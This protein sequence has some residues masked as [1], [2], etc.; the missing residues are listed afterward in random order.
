MDAITYFVH[1]LAMTKAT[2]ILAIS[3]IMTILIGGASISP[4]MAT[5][6]S[7][8]V[9]I[10][11]G[12][13]GILDGN[14]DYLITSDKHKTITFSKN[15]NIKLTCKADNVPNDSG[16]AVT[17]SGNKDSILCY[18]SGQGIADGGITNNWHLSVSASGKA[19]LTCLF[20][21]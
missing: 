13:C 10:D 6:K 20:K 5:A 18:V 2:S 1:T 3:A 16:H 7:A 19:T 12:S 14:G 17:Y 9:F 21:T 8:K 15:G 4:Q 11:D